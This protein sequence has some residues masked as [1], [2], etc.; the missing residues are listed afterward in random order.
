MN[1]GREGGLAIYFDFTCS[2]SYRV[3]RWLDRLTTTDRELV[4]D[5]RPFVLKEVNRSDEESYL[6][7]PTID[8][9]A[10]LALAIGEALRGTPALER[11]R[12]DVFPAMHEGDQRPGR[13]DVE[14]I[15]IE[16]G[17]DQD[18][19]W[20]DESLW[21]GSVRESHEGA[22][23]R[24][25]VFG[26]PTL[27]VDDSNAMY[28]KLDEPIPEDEDLLASIVGLTRDFPQLVELKRPAVP[29]PASEP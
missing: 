7:G 18:A 20:R 25:G 24:W 15:A 6:A 5:W 2:Y 28:L 22:V 11:Y 23:A 16:A 13:E 1:G 19:F 12:S 26:T 3:W 9:V 29:E 8:S 27:I 4:V 17:L 14:R 21:L 10:V